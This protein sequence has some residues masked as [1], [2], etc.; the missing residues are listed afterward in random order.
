[1]HPL[2]RRVNRA[3]RD[4]ALVS[5]GDRVAVAVSGGSDSVA[6]ARL[7]AELA[8]RARWSLVGLVHVNHQLRPEADADEQFVSDLAARMLLPFDTTRVDV[9]SLVREA[10]RS[11]ETVAREARY[12]CLSA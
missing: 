3:L 2:A 4:R 6:L 7:L 9:P 11:L 8:P 10:R 12:R 5:D 1:M